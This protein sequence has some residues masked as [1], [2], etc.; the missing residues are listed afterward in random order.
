MAMLGTAA[1]PVLGCRCLWLLSR[2]WFHSRGPAD[3]VCPLSHVRLGL[4]LRTALPLEE[5]GSGRR[6]L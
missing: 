3:L 1:T 2:R 6:Q 4:L 5:A